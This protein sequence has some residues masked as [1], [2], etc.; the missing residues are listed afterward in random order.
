M[1]TVGN[2]LL[3][4]CSDLVKRYPGFTLG[5]LTFAL[6][7]GEILGLI[8]RNGAGKSTLLRSIMGLIHIDQGKLVLSFAIGSDRK[9]LRN[10]IGYISDR[11]NFYEWMTVERAIAFQANFFPLW[12]KD[13]VGDLLQILE[14]DSKKAIKDLST[15]NRLKLALLL[16][17]CQGAQM[18]ILD[19]PT[20]GLD[21]IV[22]E[23]LLR[24]IRQSIDN[25]WVRG[26]ILASHVLSEVAAIA[27]RV[28]ILHQGLIVD[29]F[30]MSELQNESSTNECAINLTEKFSARCLEAMR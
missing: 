16:C 28:I 11:P 10:A 19:E 13:R 2:E 26:A 7:G 17:L 4:E 9:T 5:S 29:E 30:S 23:E 20:S 1:R 14:L 3:I 24:L 6:H 18:L 22:R 8:G 21:P 27:S 25:G 12:K 15:G